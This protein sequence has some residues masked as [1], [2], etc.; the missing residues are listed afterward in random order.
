MRYFTKTIEVPMQ[1]F[2]TIFNVSPYVN[3]AEFPSKSVL[4]LFPQIHTLENLPGIKI[5]FVR[6]FLPNNI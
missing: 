4:V 1:V 3:L 6:R 2:K 5:I